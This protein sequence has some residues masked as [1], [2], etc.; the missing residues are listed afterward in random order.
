MFCVCFYIFG[1]KVSYELEWRYLKAILSQ[2]EEWF[3]TKNMES[4]PTEFYTNVAG[5]EAATGRSVAFVFYF[6]SACLSG[7]AITFICGAVFA[8]CILI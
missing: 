1:F 3:E 5:V 8:C 4:L 7:V 6:V 2:D